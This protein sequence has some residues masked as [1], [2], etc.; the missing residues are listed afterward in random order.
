[1]RSVAEID[2]EEVNDGQT[3]EFKTEQQPR[4]AV[5]TD[6]VDVT[7]DTE[8]NLAGSITEMVNTGEANALFEYRKTGTTGDTDSSPQVLTGPTSYNQT[9][10]GLDKGAEYEMRAKAVANDRDGVSDVGDWISWVNTYLPDNSMFSDPIYHWWGGSIAATDG[11]TVNWDDGLTNLTATPSGSPVYRS[12]HSGFDAVEFSDTNPDYY[13]FESD[14]NLPT[15]QSAVSFAALVY[16]NGTDDETIVGYG[17]PN[18]DEAISMSVRQ[19]SVSMSIKGSNR[20]VTAGSPSTGQ[21]ITVGGS[22]SSASE[23]AVYLNGVQKSS[24][25]VNGTLNLQDTNR[26][27]GYRY[28]NIE[29]MDGYL[30]ELI[31]SGADEAETAFSDYHT[32]RLG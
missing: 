17:A 31:I 1:M 5:V 29:P 2:G 13:S 32:D 20:D 12:G 9:I 28:D 15:G 10:T 25:T 3:I 21:W 14:G 27:I 8:A 23:L 6:A 30:G 19:S 4:I 18:S 11:E 7:S 24:S 16:L 26:K 22:A